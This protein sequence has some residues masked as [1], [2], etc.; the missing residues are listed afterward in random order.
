MMTPLRVFWANSKM[1]HLCLIVAM[2]EEVVD[3]YLLEPRTF[4][5]LPLEE[6]KDDRHPSVCLTKESL[7]SS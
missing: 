7:D 1:C 3:F 5:Q 2:R 4:N 6:V